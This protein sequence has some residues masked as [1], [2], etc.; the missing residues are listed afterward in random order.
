MFS[1]SVSPVLE[2]KPH[3]GFRQGVHERR[4]LLARL[5]AQHFF[6]KLGTIFTEFDDSGKKRRRE[7]PNSRCRL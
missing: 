6:T 1:S 4:L 3:Q 7:T 5:D 2:R